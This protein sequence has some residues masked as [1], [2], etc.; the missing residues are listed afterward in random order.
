MKTN[1][2]RVLDR[3][4]ISYEIREYKVDPDDLTAETVAAKVGLPPKQVFK[5]LVVRGDRLGVLLAMV[6]GDEELDLKALARLSGDRKVEVVALK[7]LQ[8][9]TGYIRGGVTAR[10]C[11][12]DYPAFADETILNFE[13]ISIS[14]GLRG[15]QILL[16]PQDY[17]RATKAAVGRIAR[18]KAE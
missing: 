7:E 18:P 2:A 12:K 6:P 5:T 10:A 11:K 1:A 13:V 8:T 17:L 4:G 9:L 14:A 15:M 3:L 16:T